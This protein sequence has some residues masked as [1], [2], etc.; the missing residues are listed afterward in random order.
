MPTLPIPRTYTVWSIDAWGHAPSE[1]CAGYDC[2]CIT[3]PEDEH[4]ETHDEVHDEDRCRCDYQFND[5]CRIGTIELSPDGSSEEI[6]TALCEDFLRGVP[7]L[8]EIDDPSYDGENFY[9]NAVKNGK[10][11]LQVEAE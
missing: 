8:Y 3:V 5:R 1:C 2:P 4:G 6:L 9:V 10:P 7:A 11:I